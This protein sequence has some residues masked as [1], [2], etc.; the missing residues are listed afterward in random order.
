MTRSTRS[1]FSRLAFL[2]AALP[3]ACSGGGGGGSPSV[4]METEPNDGPAQANALALD[5]PGFG[6]IDEIGD[7]ERR[8]FALPDIEINQI[9]PAFRRRGRDGRRVWKIRLLIIRNR[10]RAALLVK[11]CIKFQRRFAVVFGE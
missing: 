10:E 11:D 7:F 9:R 2:L 4:L 3:L 8:H 5:R 1:V 6:N